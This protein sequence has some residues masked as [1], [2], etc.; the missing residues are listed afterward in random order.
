MLGFIAFDRDSIALKLIVG[1]E[2]K[3]CED[4]DISYFQYNPKGLAE[5]LVLKVEVLV[6]TLGSSLHEPKVEST[7]ATT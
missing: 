6:S 4:V 2:L 5:W 1:D 3:Y 7:C